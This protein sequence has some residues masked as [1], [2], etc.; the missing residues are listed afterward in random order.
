MSYIEAL[1][2]C[3]LD[4]DTLEEL[5]ALMDRIVDD[6]ELEL[7]KYPYYLEKL[8]RILIKPDAILVISGMS[9][10]P[11]PPFLDRVLIYKDHIRAPLSTRFP[12]EYTFLKRLIGA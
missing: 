12:N 11:V 4:Q 10:E 8:I 9:M 1:N 6:D 7:L 5:Y 3:N 2:A